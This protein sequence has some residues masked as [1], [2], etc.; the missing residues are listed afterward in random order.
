MIKDLRSYR[1]SFSTGGLL[2]NESVDVARL[3]SPNER[4]D[5]TIAHALTEGVASLPKAVSQRRTL[6]EIVNRISAL[7]GAE[8]VLLQETDDRTE[9]KALLWLA[10]CRAYRFVNEFAVEVL[11]DRH[12]SYRIDLPLE[13]FDVFWEEKAD[14][15]PELKDISRST[16]LKLRQVLF[17]MMREADV[18]S[19]TG[20]IQT[21][22]LT[23]QI[24][25]LIAETR[26]TD[27][28]V[29][30]GIPFDETQK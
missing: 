27:L 30:P 24:T 14:W 29:F 15:H 18:L 4:W 17:R 3:H 20:T 1:M 11:R 19:D 28:A 9:Q 12:L 22:Y 21:A 2:L 23:P 26:P 6:R 8:L 25:A 10:T 5:E 7:T 13:T 16:Q